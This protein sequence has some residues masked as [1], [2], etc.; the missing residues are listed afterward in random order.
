MHPIPDTVPRDAGKTPQKDSCHNPYP[1][2][3]SSSPIPWSD[4]EDETVGESVLK[5]PVKTP[6]TTGFA[7]PGQGGP[8][9]AIRNMAMNTPT[10]AESSRR[11]YKF[12]E[13]MNTPPVP[14]PNFG[15]APP[16]PKTPTAH[17]RSSLNPEVMRT[18]SSAT[19]S[20]IPQTPSTSG[21][22]KPIDLVTDVSEILSRAGVSLDDKTQAELQDLLSKS[23]RKTQGYIKA[24]V[25]PCTIGLLNCTN[26]CSFYIVVM[27]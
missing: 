21:S 1:P 27:Q 19:Q 22:D 10:T 2:E 3:P 23:M 6:R 25:L 14:R 18:P 17:R 13:A 5:T 24:Q 15:Q 16:T 20:A 4:S 9:T 26:V 11:A 7:S 12:Q 8:A